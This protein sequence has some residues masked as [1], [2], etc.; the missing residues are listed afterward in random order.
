MI[1]NDQEKIAYDRRR[2]E[3]GAETARTAKSEFGATMSHEVRTPMNAIL[4]MTDLLLLTDLTRKQLGYIQVIQSSGDMLLSLVDNMLDFSQLEAGGLVIEKRE[5]DVADLLE[6]VLEIMGYQAYSTG[7]EL[8]GTIERDPLLRVSGDKDRLR[9]I[10][11]NLVSN[12]IKYTNRGEVIIRIRLDTAADGQAS[13]F[14]EV[15]DSGIGMSESATA[16]LFTPFLQVDQESGGPQQ[17][18][19]L[20]LA[21]SKQLVDSMGGEFGIESALGEGT[22]AW[23]TVPVDAIPTSDEDSAAQ[24]RGLE[25][26][27]ALIVDDNRKIAEI[28]CDYLLAWGMTCEELTNAGDVLT[29]LKTAAHEQYP[30][31]CVVIDVDM[32][33]TDGLTLAREIR[34]EKDVEKLPI[35]LLTSIARPLKVGKISSI[36]GIRCVNKPVLSTELRHNLFRAM[37]VDDGRNTVE[38]AASDPDIR[39][40]VAEDNPINRNLLLGLLKS[41][42]YPADW[43]QDGP[44]VLSTL[45]EQHYDLIL[46]DCQMPGMDGDEVTREIRKNRN[47]YRHPPIVIAV[48]ADASAEHKTACLRAG[49]DDFLAKPVRLET[50]KSGLRR[51]STLAGKSTPNSDLAEKRLDFAVEQEAMSQLRDRAGENGESFLSN[52]I[53]L[54]LQDTA[55]RLESLDAALERKDYEKLSR[56]SH[57]LKGACLEFGVARMSACC[58]VLRDAGRHERFDEIPD[59]LLRLRREFDR[60]RPAFEAEKNRLA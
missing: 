21:I 12:A 10:L 35:I 31:D 46:M 39:I 34:A 33:G 48:T 47:L 38:V 19:G 40:L 5:F 55:S 20:G 29:H 26:R 6:W 24:S 7:L 23:F 27:R 53:D 43:V 15:S 36:G 54:F 51:W 41:L 58:D 59:A 42:D 2:A 60:I 18:S 11:V 56:E 44:A 30:F 45:A 22:R 16:L 57:A 17:G 37:E 32:P 28:I 25:N 13:L 1:M 14:F 4:G 8:A 52:Y 3:D 9:Q 49:M 50:L